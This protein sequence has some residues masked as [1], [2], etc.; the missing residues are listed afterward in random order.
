MLFVVL[1]V[2]LFVY[3]G[4]F[5]LIGGTDG[6][7]KMWRVEYGNIRDLQMFYGEHQNGVKHIKFL[8]YTDTIASCC[9]EIHV[10]D[11]VQCRTIRKFPTQ[12]R[13]KEPYTCMTDL[14][15]CCLIA[16]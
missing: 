5:F 1:F 9:N 3:T 4:L 16:G 12:K 6:L 13:E 2:V 7:V 10:W 14:N 11:S 15:Y 8:K